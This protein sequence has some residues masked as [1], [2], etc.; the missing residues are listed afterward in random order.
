MFFIDEN[1]VVTASDIGSVEEIKK[2]AAVCGSKVFHDETT[3]L[4]SQFRCNGSDGYINFINDLL[5]IKKTANADGFDGDYELKIYDD[6]C[7]MRA[8]LAEK[9]KINNKARMIAGYCYEWIS[10]N[11]S[12]ADIYDIELGENFKAKWNFSGT[13]TW[14]IDE[15]SFDQVGCIHT[16]QGLEF[17][18][19]GIIIG[20]DMYFKNQSLV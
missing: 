13:Q 14:A 8:D 11:S 1:Q 5:E 20:K 12:S 3:K 7:Q 16:S 17:D 15:D 2:W 6:P 9:N 10:K 18:Y 19:V 4:S